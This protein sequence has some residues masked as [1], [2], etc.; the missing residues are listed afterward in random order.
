MNGV[1]SD[2]Q[3]N[4]WAVGGFSTIIHWNG[5]KWGVVGDSAHPAAPTRDAYNAV[6]GTGGTVWVAGNSSIVRCTSVTS[7]TPDKVVGGDS[8]FGIWGTS[9]TNAWAVGAHG[10]ILHFDGTQWT[11]VT[12]PT[13]LKLVRIWGSSATNVWAVGDSAI[14]QYNGTTWAVPP[15]AQGFLKNNQSQQSGLV[16]FQIGMF[17]FAAN[18]LYVGTSYGGIQRW[19]G[20]MW[21]DVAMDSQNGGGRIVAISGYAGGCGIALIDVLVSGG[22]APL[23]RGVGPTNGCLASPMT[24][25]TPW[26]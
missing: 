9:A 12:S 17:G 22:S 18:D 4:A 24:V 8:L 10:T 21:N 3:S 14:V 13:P 23:L 7:C 15:S 1:W 26:P 2:G 19:D 11:S 20:L 25:A 5:T 16:D 6:W